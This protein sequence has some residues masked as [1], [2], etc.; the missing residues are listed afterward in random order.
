MEHDPP[1]PRMFAKRLLGVAKV[2]VSAAL[3]AYLFTKAARDDS[4]QQ[5]RE[6]PKEWGLLA[7]AL[8]VE[9]A[10]VI[11]TIV[12]WY[13]LVRAV[14]LP[15]TIREALRLGFLGFL[16]NFFTLGIVGGDAI[17]AVFVARSNP[18][19]GAV[20]VA[21]VVVDRLFGLLGLLVLVSIGYF[22]V[23]WSA[24]QTR[25]PAGLEIIQNL[26]WVALMGSA[27]GVAALGLLLLPGFTTSPLWDFFAR[28][29]GVGLTF[30]HLIAAVRMY[31]RR[32]PLLGVALLM[33]L[34]VHALLAVA[35]YLIA[36]GLPGQ[37]PGFLEHLVISPMASAF[38]SLP[39]PGGLGAFEVAL[40]FLYRRVSPERVAESQGF[41]IALAYRVMTLLIATIG[42]GYYLTSR[43]EVRRLMAEAK[44]QSEAS[45]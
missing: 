6:Q 10:A 40:D 17:R 34:L 19:R 22:F 33:S 4:F 18:G 2:A 36:H 32:A 45:S 8:L 21:T 14:E 41:V 26:C 5:L 23:D 42:V 16:L 37:T 27:V 35:I 31:R 3:L 1:R 38:G 28:P 44:Q 25:D 24:V 43:R 11:V 13:L 9:L 15:F 29:P 30:E 20:A 7:T 12:R 39:L